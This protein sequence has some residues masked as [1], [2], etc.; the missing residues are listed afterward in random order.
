M[1]SG[2]GG[3]RRREAGFTYIGLLV[4]IALIGYLLAVAGQV[5]ATT[6]QRERECELLFIGHAY[7]HAITLYFRQ[8]HRYPTAL[9]DL[10]TSTTSGPLPVHFLRHLY[11]DPFTRQVD[12]VLIAGPGDSIMGVAS[13]STAA[14]LKRSGFDDVDVGFGDAQTLRDWEFVANQQPVPAPLPQGLHGAGTGQ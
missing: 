2:E 3:G 10:L 11:P 14:P 6:A 13:S 12:W 7:R 8:N 4:L 1:P 5:A 9:A